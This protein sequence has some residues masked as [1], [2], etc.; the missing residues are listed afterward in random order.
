MASADRKWGLSMAD[1]DFDT[2]MAFVLAAEGG[3]VDDPRDPGGATNLGITLRVLSDWRHTAVTKQEVKDLTP[4]EA[5]AIYRARYWNT[6]RCGELPAGVDL[7]VFDTA[8]NLGPGR[9]AKMLQAAVGTD[10]DGSVG[11]MTVASAQAGNAAAIVAAI[12][13]SRGDFYHSLPTFDH[14]GAGWMARLSTAKALADSL[15]ATSSG[16]AG[17]DDLPPLIATPVAR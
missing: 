13:K 6:T 17:P 14:F 12:A 2:C 16:T 5:K 15:I 11:P 9:A 8:V 7:M 1:A 10:Q 4:E 3:Y